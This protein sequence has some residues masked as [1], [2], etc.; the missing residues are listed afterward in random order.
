MRLLLLLAVAGA[1]AAF[2]W[3]DVKQYLWEHGDQAV[4]ATAD[5]AS[6]VAAEGVKRTVHVAG[7]VAT[8]LINATS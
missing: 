4:D 2:G 8:R 6:K 1:A 5:I 7:Y 3:A